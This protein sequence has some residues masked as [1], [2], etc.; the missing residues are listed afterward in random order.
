MIRRAN[1]RS[2]VLSV[3]LCQAFTRPT[4]LT[5]DLPLTV[6]WPHPPSTFEGLKFRWK[7]QH[8]GTV[9]E[10]LLEKWRR[11]VEYGKLNP[12]HPRTRIHCP[13]NQ[14]VRVLGVIHKWSF[15]KAV[16]L[17]KNVMVWFGMV[18]LHHRHV[19]GWFLTY[20]FV[21]HLSFCPKYQFLKS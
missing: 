17:V 3:M 8:R 13:P 10:Y 19:S 7:L 18:R 14:T 9:W 6:F 16:K 21:K 11:G 12:W 2:V 20:F 4:W 1:C 5:S 15:K